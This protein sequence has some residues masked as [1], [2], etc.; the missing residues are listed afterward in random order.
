MAETS[1][2][3]GFGLFDVTAKAD[4][5]S[6]EYNSKPAWL[7]INGLKLD[8]VYPPKAATLEQN[9]WKLDGSF[10]VFPQNPYNTTWGYWNTSQSGSSSPYAFSTVPYLEINFNGLHESGGITFE[11]NPYDNSYCSY[12]RIQWFKDDTVLADEEFN[13]DN[14]RYTCSKKVTGYNRIRIDFYRMN[15]AYRYLKIQNIAYGENI[16]FP[17]KDLI[18]ASLLEE[19][20]LTSAQLSINTLDFTVYSSDKKFSIWNPDEVY[21]LLQK[22]QQLITEGYIDG[23][24]I[25]LGTYYVDTWETEHKTVQISAVDAVGVLDTTV[26]QGGLY[27]DKPVSELIS[28]ILEDA[29]FGYSIDGDIGEK[30]V[31]GWLP[32]CTHREALQ[33]TAFAA[34]AFIDTSGGMIRVSE[35]NTAGI[36]DL[37]R[38]RKFQGSTASLKSYVTEV[39]L[40]AHQYVIGP[41]ST[42]LFSGELPVGVSEVAFSGPGI[43]ANVDNEESTGAG[44]V[45]EASRHVNGC[46]VNV[47]AAGTIVITGRPYED[48]TTIVKA[49]VPEI[50]PGEQEGIISITDATLISEANAGETAQKLLRYYQMRKEQQISFVRDTEA[51]GNGVNVEVDKGI[52]RSGVITKMETDLTGGFVTKAVVIGE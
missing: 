31:T 25:N 19:T 34:G 30:T 17:D 16:F 14:W 39:D 22:K 49:Q 28:E 33:Q 38:D 23:R 36:S 6:I 29:G 48:N 1:V 10:D 5:E 24:L 4:I 40:T 35:L 41:T 12:L 11:F 47:T 7:D 3:I 32:R 52:W 15:K 13:P 51:V 43:Y 26:F 2:N 44:A 37:G 46:E 27:M 20:D 42:T 45:I 18:S 21:D 50:E 9:Y 8:G